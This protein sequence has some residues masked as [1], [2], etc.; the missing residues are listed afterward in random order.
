M[1]TKIISICNHKG[2]VGKTS[3]V[4]SVGTALAKLGHS[5]LLVDLDAQSNLT[6]SLINYEPERTTYEALKERKALPVIKI[7]D[8]G[9]A[10]SP[11][12]LDLAGIELEMANYMERE[13]TLKDVLDEVADKYEYILLDCPP[14]LGLLTLN[15]L[16]ASTDV[17]IPLMAEALPSKGLQKIIDIIT[18]TQKRLNTSLRLSGIVITRYEKSNLGSLVEEAVREKYGEIVFQTK[19]RKNVAIAEA[20]LVYKNLLD[21]APESNGA[22]DYKA[23]AEEIEARFSTNN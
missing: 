12:S 16:T 18:M 10:L 1:K 13:K 21:Y 7:E 6:S 15:A 22:K 2:G 11:A 14:S 23:L 20:P 5:V 9:V 17:V 4:A 3:T 19:I 8:T